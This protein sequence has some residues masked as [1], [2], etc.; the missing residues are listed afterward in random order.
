M[1]KRLAAAA[2]IA[3]FVGVYFYGKGKGADSI[4]KALH[5]ANIKH[6][7]Q[8]AALNR[9]WE[10]EQYDLHQETVAQYAV[11][12][13]LRS[14]SDGLQQAIRDERAKHYASA[15]ELRASRDRALDVLEAC[16]AEY[17]AM[18]QDADAVVNALRHGQRWHKTY[19][20]K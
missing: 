15:A 2:V 4:N 9:K 11:I 20:I 6:Q 1:P 7:E 17:T 10:I 3:A 19:F 16:R 12:D 5:E 8:I 18:A 13:S 14:S